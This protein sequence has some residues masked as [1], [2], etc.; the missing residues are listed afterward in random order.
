MTRSTRDH[1]LIREALPADAADAQRIMHA[2]H[3]WNAANG[4]NFTA[5]FITV[6]D[7]LA[8]FAVPDR[9]YVALAGDRLVGT[10]ELKPDTEHGSAL[11]RLQPPGVEGSWAFGMLTVQP[12][13]G[14]SGVGR[15]LI[16]FAAD[17]SRSRGA[18]QLTL[19]TPENH[20]WLPGYYGRLGFVPIAHYQW[21][22][23]AYRS[24]VMARPLSG[25][26]TP[27]RTPRPAGA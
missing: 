3:A 25:P 24:V 2:A 15:E 16:E 1:L 27:F 10:I 19:D 13:C 21:E 17:E 26:G 18:W 12:G 4:F 14:L 22:G 9:F 6:E 8:K 5:S 7:L 20:P 23:K 11:Y